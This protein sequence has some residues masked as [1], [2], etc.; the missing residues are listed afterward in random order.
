LEKVFLKL[1]FKMQEF[2]IKQINYNKSSKMQ[3]IKIDLDKYI[4]S[5]K[6][7][8]IMVFHKKNMA[9]TYVNFIR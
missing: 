4:Y 1:K 2:G 9:I 8:D 5:E 6:K 7:I 3:C